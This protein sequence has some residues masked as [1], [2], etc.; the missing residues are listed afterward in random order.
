[1]ELIRKQHTCDFSPKGGTVV[2]FQLVVLA[3]KPSVAVLLH[4][5][6]LQYSTMYGNTAGYK[7]KY[8]IVYCRPTAVKNAYAML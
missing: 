7:N 1:M 2:N 6:P 4:A 8:G 3:A 5:P